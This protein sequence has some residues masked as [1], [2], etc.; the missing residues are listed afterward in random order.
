VKENLIMAGYLIKQKEEFEKRMGLVL[1]LFPRL[2][3]YMAKK[4]RT[5]SGGKRQMPAMAMVLMKGPK[6]LLLDDPAAA[7]APKVVGQIFS[8]IREVVSSGITVLLVEQHARRA[9]SLCHMGYVM[10]GGKVVMKGPDSEL[11]SDEKFVEAFLGRA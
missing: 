5:L 1:E 10:S 6:V 9:L 2:K 4:A 8:R 11:L 3:G 7:L